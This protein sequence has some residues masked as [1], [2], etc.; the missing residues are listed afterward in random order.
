M[1][2]KRKV[3]R[4]IDV[5]GLLCPGP[6]LITRKTL[7]EME[8]GKTLEVISNDK[9]TKKS[10]PLICKRTKYRLVKIIEKN[11]LLHFI[12]ET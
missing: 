5:S 6:D 2:V 3:D 9:T 7:S 4:I 11:G 8:K 1:T 12:I 10:I